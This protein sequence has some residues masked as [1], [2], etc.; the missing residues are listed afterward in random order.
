MTPLY[1]GTTNLP[2][3]GCWH[4]GAAGS[5]LAVLVCA[6][7]GPE[8]LSAY[9]GLRQL[10]CALAAAGLPVL[11]FD[12]AGAGDSAGEPVA[13]D[14]PAQWLQSVHAA[15][16][17]LRRLSGAARLALVGLRLGGLL[18]A[19]AAATRDDVEA[20]AALMPVASGRSWLREC[21]LLS[22]G[23]LTATTARAVLEV[24]HL[25][26]AAPAAAA[27]DAL[28]WPGAAAHP[29]AHALLMDGPQGP[30]RPEAAPGEVTGS[31][32]ALG[33]IEA[34]LQAQGA[35][36]H[37]V[38]CPGLDRLARLAHEAEL[39]LLAIDR[40]TAWLRERSAALPPV[41]GAG[42]AAAAAA[43]AASTAPGAAQALLAFGSGHVL[44]RVVSLG[45]PL[46]LVGV[47]ST[48]AA[49]VAPATPSSQ[50][51][52][53]LSSGAERRTGPHRLWVEFA[54]QRAAAGD[55]VLRL[56][57]PGIG[58]SDDR[59]STDSNG[60]NSNSNGNGNSPLD[61]YDDRC[62]ADIAT[63]LRWLRA[64]CG[65]S[66]CGVAGLCS[67]A[68]HAWRA[69]LQ[70]VPVSMVVA[71][72]PL[73]FHWKAGM[74]LDPLAHAFGAISI[75]ARA[76]QSLLDPHRWAKLLRGR[77]NVRV[78]AAAVVACLRQG[79]H[80]QLRSL[81]RTVGWPIADDLAKELIG[82]T[83]RGAQ[84]CFVFSE[85]EPGQQ[86]LAQQAG[87][88]LARLRRRRQVLLH[89]VPAAD[90]TF[91]RQQARSALYAVL[92]PLLDA[93]R[94]TT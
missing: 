36:V 12:Y 18:A 22:A 42:T 41:A 77:A 9:R 27:I 68:Y 70:G 79:L 20:L 31:S 57:L 81:A 94:Q 1:F 67:G 82:V 39:P 63:A 8:E 88:T 30:E 19:Q 58:D 43:T 92:H 74:S 69:A 56:D 72:N 6:P 50:G 35:A 44:E 14:P 64:E 93:A 15:A 80:S 23:A 47:L 78:I 86:L 28:R 60:N 5:P 38:A 71:I 89:T 48:P 62:V 73:V 7:L 21:R 90:H 65:V 10:A 83:R 87:R 34:A 91:S 46:R 84:L 76:R 54:R 59:S 4:A 16:D 85:A 33:R 49:G 29:L 2:L 26:I 37:M 51:W 66:R 40:L 11:R 3:S 17:E 45:G 55:I 61:I 24:G 75:A 13:A 52:L 32:P 53:L 25:V